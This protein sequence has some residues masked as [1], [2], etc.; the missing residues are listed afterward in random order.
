MLV[1]FFEEGFGAYH[2][3]ALTVQ[4][5]LEQITAEGRG[6][7]FSETGYEI[8][9]TWMRSAF[10]EGLGNLGK[11]RTAIALIGQASEIMERNE[12]RYFEAEIHRIRGELILKKM[13][14]S[15][16]PSG[17]IESAEAAA[18]QSF[19]EAMVIARRQNAR[20]FELRA[21]A[22][23]GRLLGRTGKEAEA[24]ILLSG[25][26]DWFTEGFDTP[27]LAAARSLLDSFRN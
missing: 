26:C 8:C 10:A 7:R 19:R 11:I 18:E 15:T 6:R 13:G 3:I 12:E 17:D 2:L 25:T 14:A 22:S 23:L 20:M 21:A 5:N 4:G 27:D 1:G 9:Q 24:R 16:D